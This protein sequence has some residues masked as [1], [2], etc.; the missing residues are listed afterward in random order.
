MKKSQII[1]ISAIVIAI[2]GIYIAKQC[3]GD[4]HEH[5]ENCGHI[6]VVHETF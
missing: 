4:I 6:Q 5:D 2:V 1:I 3:F